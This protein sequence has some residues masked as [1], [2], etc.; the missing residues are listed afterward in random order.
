MKSNCM[1][2]QMPILKLWCREHLDEVREAPYLNVDEFTTIM[3]N[4]VLAED[5]VPG[6]PHKVLEGRE[7]LTK[8]GKASPICCHLGDEEMKDLILLAQ[9]AQGL[10]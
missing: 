5:D 9:D 2:A 8:I 4:T 3:V 1:E 7:I 6:K 10:A